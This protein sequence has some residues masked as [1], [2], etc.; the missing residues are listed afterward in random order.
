ML[1]TRENYIWLNIS[2]ACEIE[3]SVNISSY[4]T[5]E[6]SFFGA[7]ELTKHVEVDQYK[8]SGY[9]IELIKKDLIQLVMKSIEL[10]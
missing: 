7:V 5:L 4:P 1:K 8:C 9:G 10:W 6:N 3:R 2:I